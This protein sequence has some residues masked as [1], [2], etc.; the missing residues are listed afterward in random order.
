MSEEKTYRDY[1]IECSNNNNI[2]FVRLE[3]PETL[4][5]MHDG[6]IKIDTKLVC[7]FNDKECSSTNCIEVNN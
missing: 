3:K 2:A 5:T 1:F 7:K 4:E 6:V